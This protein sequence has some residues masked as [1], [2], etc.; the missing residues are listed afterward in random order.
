MKLVYA[1]DDEGATPIDTVL[2]RPCNLKFFFEMVI[3]M[4]QRNL[5]VTDA[6]YV[7]MKEIYVDKF[8]YS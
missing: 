6:S 5:S 7:C 1:N 8:L 2:R 3:L 4:L